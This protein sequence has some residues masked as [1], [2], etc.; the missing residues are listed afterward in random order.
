MHLKARNWNRERV[1]VLILG[2]PINVVFFFGQRKLRQQIKFNVEIDSLCV[3][4][5][6]LQVLPKREII[7]IFED[8]VDMGKF[9]LP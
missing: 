2:K 3:P 6:H 5:S 1:S 9:P 4:I 8:S 7:F